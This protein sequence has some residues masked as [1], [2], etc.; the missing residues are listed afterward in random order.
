[1]LCQAVSARAQASCSSGTR[2]N[3]PSC[4]AASL[5]ARGGAASSTA[6]QPVQSIACYVCRAGCTGQASRK[7]PAAPPAPDYGCRTVQLPHCGQVLLHLWPLLQPRP[8]AR[9]AGI[10]PHRHRG[11]QQVRRGLQ[12]GAS[13]AGWAGLRQHTVQPC[14]TMQ[15]RQTSLATQ[16]AKRRC[17]SK[18]PTCSSRAHTTAYS[19]AASSP[20]ATW[21]PAGPRDG[22]AAAQPGCCGAAAGA[23]SAGRLPPSRLLRADSGR[24][25]VN[26]AAGLPPL[27]SLLM[28]F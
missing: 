17:S 28:P 9:D 21:A 23:G 2:E 1:M 14:T 18:L 24:S 25:T 13:A 6:S 27:P 22:P 19:V 20:G 16:L 11:L 10:R 3:R 7:G 4:C 5:R 8:A 26:T 12:A 15:T